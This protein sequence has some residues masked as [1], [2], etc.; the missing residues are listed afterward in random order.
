MTV[1]VKPIKAVAIRERLKIS[2]GAFESSGKISL[3]GAFCAEELTRETNGRL[4]TFPCDRVQPYGRVTFILKI[5]T[6]VVEGGNEVLFEIATMVAPDAMSLIVRQRG[7]PNLIVHTYRRFAFRATGF[8]E[9][10]GEGYLGPSSIEQAKKLSL[11]W[12]D[13]HWDVDKQMSMGQSVTLSHSFVL[14]EKR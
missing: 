14:Y 12:D 3:R 7:G 1:A 13:L 10:A 5:Q 9:I 4:V 6:T 2:S 8:E 11:S